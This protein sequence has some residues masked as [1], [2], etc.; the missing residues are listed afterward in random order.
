V[1]DL[2]VAPSATEK[3]ILLTVH[4]PAHGGERTISPSHWGFGQLAQYA[5]APAAYL[6]RLPAP[7]AAINLQWGLERDGLRDEALILGSNGDYG[8][9]P[10]VG[11]TLRA[12]TS[13]SYG[14][15]WDREVVAAPSAP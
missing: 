9:G 4:D 3:D 1:R 11:G 8:G 6:R 7:L 10:A 2:R 5:N 12:V 14:R 13:T 15:I